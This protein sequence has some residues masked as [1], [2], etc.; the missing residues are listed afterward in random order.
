[1]KIGVRLFNIPAEDEFKYV[2][3]KGNKIAGITVPI[4]LT[5]SKGFRYFNLNFLKLDI[6]KG[7]K[8]KNAIIK[9]KHA[10]SKYVNPLSPFFIKIK[11]EPQIIDS[12]NNMNQLMMI[13]LDIYFLYLLSYK[14]LKA[15]CYDE[16]TY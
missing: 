2:W 11:D 1:M 9:R 15:I 6:K 5:I 7:V 13:V 14:F 3:P 12:I 4:K 16:Q 8:T 10:I